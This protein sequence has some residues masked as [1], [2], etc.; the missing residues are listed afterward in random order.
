MNLEQR[1]LFN[2]PIPDGNLPD[3]GERGS[4]KGTI[5]N[6][7]ALFLHYGIT[8]QYDNIGK[9]QRVTF[10]NQDQDHDLSE[11]GNYAW[12]SSLLSLNNLPASTMN[13][14]PALMIDNTA[15]PVLDFITNTKHD[16]KDYFRTVAD[17]LMVDDKD[18]DYRD[19]A[20]RTWFYQCVAAADSAKQ[21]MANGSSKFELVFVLQGPQ[22][23]GK[24]TWF[25]SLVP[26]HL[27]NYVATGEHLDPDDTN[28]LRRCLSTWICELGELDAT[29]RKS[30]IERLKA[31]LSQSEDKIRLPY[32]R[33]ISNYKRR[34]SFCGSVNPEQFLVDKTGNRRFLPIA[35]KHINRL[36]DSE[37]FLQGFWS[38]IWHEY[39]TDNNAIW[40]ANNE[41]EQMLQARHDNHTETSPIEELIAKKFDLLNKDGKFHYTS[42]DILIFCGIH[43]PSKTQVKEVKPFLEKLKITAVQNNGNRGFWLS[44]NDF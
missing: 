6:L 23:L 21:A 7:T 10:A 11:S 37:P 4:Y 40:W 36:T 25:K 13:L 1:L 28:S 17:S 27:Q 9:N 43:N 30:D 24:T 2:T 39:T 15:N 41:L 26:E 38:Q 16:G 33:A 31:F 19:L 22:G 29:F 34:T 44:P 18:K 42:T 12:L 35:V 32:D 14:L 20:L 8:C 5:A 3:K